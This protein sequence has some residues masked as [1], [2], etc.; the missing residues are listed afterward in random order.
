MNIA[1]STIQETSIKDLL[2]IKRKLY[3]DSR[4]SFQELARV[5]DVSEKVGRPVSLTQISIAETVPNGFRGI[6]AEEQ[7]K[8][9]SP[10]H[11]KVFVAFVDIR[12]NSPTFRNIVAQSIDVSENTPERTAIF[13]P[14][15]VGNSLLNIGDTN[16]IYMYAIS[17]EYD[18]NMVKRQFS[19]NDPELKI[20][21]PI[22][23]EEMIMSEVD[24]NN[25][26]LRQLIGQ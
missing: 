23:W 3:P 2:I 8:L 7:D 25:P 22:P 12:P 19:G 14:E 4:G 16:L 5:K 13:V 10:I 18:P 26:T 9:V 20:A 24:R 17:K 6:H 1:N 11:G 15:G 21:W